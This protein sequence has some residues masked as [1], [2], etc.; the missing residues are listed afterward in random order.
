VN[1]ENLLYNTHLRLRMEHGFLAKACLVERLYFT[2]GT[3]SG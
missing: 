1:I 2:D 3:F